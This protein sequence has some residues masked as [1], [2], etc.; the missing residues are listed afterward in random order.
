MAGAWLTRDKFILKLSFFL[1]FNKQ[2][3][4]QN[5]NGLQGRFHIVLEL[6][7]MSLPDNKEGICCVCHMETGPHLGLVRQTVEA[8][9]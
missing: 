8:G 9:N 6:D 7:G 4:W 5:T 2:F 3:D 1:N